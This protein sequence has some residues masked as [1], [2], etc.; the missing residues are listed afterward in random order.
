MQSVHTLLKLAQLRCTGHVTRMPD[1]RLPKKVLY[2]E[3]QEG[4]RSQGGQKKHYKDTLKALLN[5]ISIFQLSPVN[6]L[7]RI[8]QSGVAS[9]TKV[10]PNLKK[11][12]SV[13]LT[14]SVKKG[15]QEPKNHHQSQ[16]SPNSHALFATDSLELKL[17]YTAINEHTNTH[18]RLTFRN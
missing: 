5:S 11:R 14:G 17:A 7:I 9:S 6:R 3:L 18:K 15:K 1:E 4:K 8:E 13:K 10:P 16:H 2:G 12:E